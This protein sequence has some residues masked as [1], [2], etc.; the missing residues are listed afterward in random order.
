M[1]NDEDRQAEIDRI[2]KE[3]EETHAQEVERKTAEIIAKLDIERLNAGINKTVD[4]SSLEAAQS[5]RYNMKD[6]YSVGW[7]DPRMTIGRV[8]PDY[9]IVF[10]NNVSDALGAEQVQIGKLD[11]NGGVMKFE[12]NAD[13]S[14]MVFMDSLATT[15]KGRLNAEHISAAKVLLELVTFELEGEVELDNAYRKGFNDGMAT[16]R[17]VLR[18]KIQEMERK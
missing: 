17:A 5:M 8:K 12:G 14:A 18:K 3:M 4:P 7:T 11:F 10:K 16:C 9:N 2:A 13:Q 6:R 1:E 15:F